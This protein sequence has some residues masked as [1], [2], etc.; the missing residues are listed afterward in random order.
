MVRGTLIFLCFLYNFVFKMTKNFKNE[1]L[2]KCQKYHFSPYD[3]WYLPE[4][5][6]TLPDAPNTLPELETNH[7]ASPAMYQTLA[8]QNPNT[9]VK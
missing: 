1:N 3:L 7:H 8:A 6:R 2:Q 4:A 5:S 9:I